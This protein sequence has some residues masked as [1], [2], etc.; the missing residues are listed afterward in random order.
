[1][2]PQGAHPERQDDGVQELPVLAEV[3][4]VAPE[5]EWAL[6]HH[7][8]LELKYSDQCSRKVVL[9]DAAA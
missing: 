1:M 9:C 6:Q 3:I 8:R 5:V 2:T 4:H 7:S